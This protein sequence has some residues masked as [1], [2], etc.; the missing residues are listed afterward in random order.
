V[1][2][3]RDIERGGLLIALVV[4]LSGVFTPLASAADANPQGAFNFAV[5]PP[6]V[7]IVAKPGVP[8]SFDIRIQNQGI[9]T[10]KVKA[11][12]MKFT[13]EGETGLPNLRSFEATDDFSKWAQISPTSFT[14][15][16]NEWKTIKFSLSPPK[17]AAFGYYYAVV[18]SRQGADL[19]APKAKTSNLL[20]AVASLVLV[21]VQAPGAIRH[22]NIAEFSTVTRSGEFLPVEFNVRLRNTGNTHVG[23]RGT[24]NISQHGKTIADIDVNSKKGYILPGSFR[25]FATQWK[26]GS[27]V[28]QNATD[29]QGKV[30]YDADGKPKQKLVWDKFSAS[31]LRFGKYDA[32]LIIV[33]DDGKGDVSTTAHLSFWVIPWRI[34]AL[35]GV[36]FLLVAGGIWAVVIRPLVRGVRKNRGYAVRR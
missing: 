23:I 25:N 20:G 34:I 17:E 10:E 15:E 35:F 19:A 24:V 13:A 22:V 2:S 8:M 21:D 33:Y 9:A 1:I 18:F 5:S 27:P 28:Y 11:T 4:L 26:D 7:G 36:L 12:L 29:A 6:S 16:P 32:R 3:K 14:A 30:L 31:K